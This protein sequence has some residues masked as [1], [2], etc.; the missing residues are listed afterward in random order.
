MIRLTKA[1]DIAGALKSLRKN[2]G[3][4]RREI[5]FAVGMWEQQYGQYEMGRRVPDLA[6]LLK[7]A[8]ALGYDLALIPREDA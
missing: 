2:R 3:A 1:T 5:A 4:P 8:H 7:L 6:T